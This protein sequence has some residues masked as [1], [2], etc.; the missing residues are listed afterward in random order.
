MRLVL[1]TSFK[2]FNDHYLVSDSLNK[3]K[4]VRH[5][6]KEVKS[7]IY[8][9][10]GGAGEL[11]SAVDQIGERQAKVEKVA[12]ERIKT[13]GERLAMFLQ[14]A[15]AV[16][17][18]VANMVAVNQAELFRLHPDLIPP[19]PVKKKKK[20]LWQRFKDA[21]KKVG[22]AIVKGV[23]K[24][25][26][27]IKDTA[28]KVWKKT[29]EFCKK[30]WKAIVKIVVGVV[31]I[32]GLAALSVVTGGAAAPLFAL[33][34]KGAA[35]AACT[36]AAVT[37][38]SG[39]AKGQ[40]F[41]EIFDA[42]A[43][44]FLIGSIT[45]AVGGFAGAAAGSVASATGS[46]LLGELTKI[47]IETAGKVLAE[48]TSFL[49][50]KGTLSGFMDQKGYAIL[51]EGGMSMLS[52]VGSA[53][54]GYFKTTG[55]ELLGNTF[56]GLKDSQLVNS[57]KN[58]YS[59]CENQAPT[60]TKIVTDSFTDTFGNMSLSDLA[61]LKNPSEFAKGIGNS[62][63]S[64]LGDKLAGAADDLIGVDL[65]NITGGAVDDIKGFVGDAIGDI[66]GSD[67]GKAIGGAY[68][69]LKGEIGGAYDQLKGEIGGAYDQLKGELG[70]AVSQVVGEFKGVTGSLSVI[71]TDIGSMV[72]NAIGDIGGQLNGIVGDIGSIG[73]DISH[74]VSQVTSSV[75][76]GG[77]YL[78][79]EFRGIEGKLGAVVSTA[80]GVIRGPVPA[81]VAQAGSKPFGNML[82]TMAGKATHTTASTM[83]RNTNTVLGLLS[84]IRL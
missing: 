52:S 6:F 37:V 66:R 29:V 22:R 33:A 31:V 58:A 72:N 5:V 55:M 70:G 15:R 10:D 57:F 11:Q 34:A 40:S 13:S 62:L 24:A 82:G 44:S 12:E 25:V 73:S 65:N 7:K 27:W 8:D 26:D 56:S 74:K 63:I 14:N 46:Q 64:N 30:H 83:I 16:D 39:V 20:S 84:K 28:K 38:V 78:S 76:N 42:G 23:K 49:I 9:M 77:S 51:K 47:G 41:G 60:L 35:I 79:N 75:A 18:K 2:S 71:R 43:N 61:N 69:Q 3:R 19:A 21:C 50:D 48:G 17:K 45:G 53:A 68:D 59:W 54:I 4:D 67:F 36:G 81:S 32:A 80:S 1:N